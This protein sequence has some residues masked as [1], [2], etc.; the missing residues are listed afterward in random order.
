MLKRISKKIVS[1]AKCVVYMWQVM[2][3]LSFIFCTLYFVDKICL[4]FEVY[5]VFMLVFL[6]LYTKRFMMH[7]QLSWSF[8]Q[9]DAV[10]N[11]EP[12]YLF[13]SIYIT[14][15]ENHSALLDTNWSWLPHVLFATCDK[16][17]LLT[18]NFIL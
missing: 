10:L 11:H 7:Q 16:F 1:N 5:E 17:A 15:I 13:E 8:S 2:M 12:F 6:Q 3:S 18:I 4:W 9:G 14:T